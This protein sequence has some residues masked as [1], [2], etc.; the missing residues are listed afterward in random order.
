MKESDSIFMS[1]IRSIEERQTEVNTEISE[2]QKAAERRAEELINELQQE[3][4]DLQRRITE[5]EE[6]RSTEDHLYLLQ[7]TINLKL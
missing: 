4:T 5:L 1:M 7:V 2:K 6:L 3:V